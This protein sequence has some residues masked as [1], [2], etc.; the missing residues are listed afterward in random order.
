M[1]EKHLYLLENTRNIVTTHDTNQQKSMPPSHFM[2][3]KKISQQFFK[4]NSSPSPWKS[5]NTKEAL[6][7]INKR[8]GIDLAP[9]QQEAIDL[10]INTN[11]MLLTGGPGVG[12]TT[13]V[14]TLLLILKSFTTAQIKL[15]APTGRAA[16][17]L[18]EATGNEAKP[19]IDY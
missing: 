9:S 19:F 3:L 2:R 10:I 15:C 16:K 5:I 8:T 4:I 18:N 12:K 13:L 6:V 1:V 7:K 14:K 17:R 11:V